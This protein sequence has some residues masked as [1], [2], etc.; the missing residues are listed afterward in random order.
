MEATFQRLQQAVALDHKGD[1]SQAI[2]FYM[3][4]IAELESLA[5]GP[6]KGDGRC[7]GLLR[8]HAEGYRARVKQL[9]VAQRQLAKQ[10]EM[11]LASRFQ[12]ME[13]RDQRERLAAIGGYTASGSEV[14]S[15]E[16]REL[17]E[18]MERLRGPRGEKGAAFSRAEAAQ[19]YQALFGESV[20]GPAGAAVSSGSAVGGAPGSTASG[21]AALSEEDALIEEARAAAAV[22]AGRRAGFGEG[23]EEDEDALIAALVAEAKDE[24]R[25]GIAG[26][27]CGEGEDDVHGA[28]KSDSDSTSGSESSSSRSSRSSSEPPAQR[29]GNQGVHGGQGR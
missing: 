28:A 16:I 15:R 19:R 23:E 14:A 25:L 22:G 26:G 20:D 5:Q 21:A 3:T 4:G 18:R 13:E 2:E 24:A 1:Y 11:E 27:G 8:H 29:G 7:T 10:R 17:G 12:A 6:Y 9:E